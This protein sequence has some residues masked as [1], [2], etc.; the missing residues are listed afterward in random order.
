MSGQITTILEYILDTVITVH[1]YI[2]G[3]VTYSPRVHVLD[4]VITVFR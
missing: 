3:V 2:L 4:L 1:E